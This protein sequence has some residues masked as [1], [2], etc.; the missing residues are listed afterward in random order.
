[1]SAKLLKKFKNKQVII[2]F[3]YINEE[4]P[5]M[6]GI[7]LDVDSE[8]YFI[9]GEGRPMFAIL[10]HSVMSIIDASEVTIGFDESKDILQ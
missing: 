6:A 2:T 10:K 8:H 9:G 4:N 7:F 1:M 3:K 5:A